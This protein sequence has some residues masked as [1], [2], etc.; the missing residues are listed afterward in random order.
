M[1][2]VCKIENKLVLF[3]NNLLVNGSK[4]SLIFDSQRHNLHHIPSSL[5]SFI[6]E[7]EKEKL[8]YLCNKYLGEEETVAQYAEFLIENEICF[9]DEL[10]LID[11][12][13]KLK[14]EWYSPT[15]ISNAIIDFSKKIDLISAICSLDEINCHYLHIRF[16]D[17][18][19]D[20]DWTALL[21]TL[22]NSSLR[23]V[24]ITCHYSYVKNLAV[25]ESIANSSKINGLH[26]FG[27]EENAEIKKY[28]NKGH[29][30]KFFGGNG[31]D[32][33]SCGIVNTDIFNTN[34]EHFTESQA[35]NT[36]LN[37]KICIDEN[38]DI[39]NCPS[40]RK[41]YGNIRDTKLEDVARDPEFQK[42]W[43]IHKDLIDVCRDC[44][45]RHVCTDCRA[46]LKNPEDI[47]SQPAKCGYNPYI[48][49]WEGLE[50]FISVE[51]W[52]EQNIS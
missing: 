13:P 8:C 33:H 47:Y 15:L 25:L 50:G 43:F 42:L 6:V 28:P 32:K 18:V 51:E 49:L 4:N 41:S 12:F 40:M 14:M 2:D 10:D 21:E 37:R 17:G 45:F 38:G 30:V 5:S 39:K 31:I 29:K 27:V 19:N 46:Y 36:C 3:S 1:Q 20:L 35:H 22:N 24:E 26:I 7:A 11:S 23:G 48:A 52:R 34:L 44:E 16:F 9:I